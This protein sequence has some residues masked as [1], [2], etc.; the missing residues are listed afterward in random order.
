MAE[1]EHDSLDERYRALGREE[2][3]AELDARI[4]DAA[5]RAAQSRPGPRR[6]MLSASIAAVIV[7]SV[8]V[9]LHVQREPSEQA[10]RLPAPGEVGK[11]ATPAE[12][13]T[14][15]APVSAPPSA[16]SAA[17]NG[18]RS[19]LTDAKLQE[20]AERQAAQAGRLSSQSVEASPERWLEQIAELRHEGR[21][22]EADRQLAEFRRRFPDYRIPEPMRRKIEPR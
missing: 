20:S 3:P 13:A 9:A 17:G 4:L 7:L 5:R 6:W 11:T 14:A 19:P 12:P 22:G 21:D 2:P 16:P 10:D 8:G 15:A 1:P 18:M